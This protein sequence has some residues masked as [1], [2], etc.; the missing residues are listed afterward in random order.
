[1]VLRDLGMGRGV[2]SGN[3]LTREKKVVSKSQLYSH[4][5]SQVDKINVLKVTVEVCT[6]FSFKAFSRMPLALC[7]LGTS[8]IT[9]AKH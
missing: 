1:V 6:K 2:V 3:G 7:T 5:I 9:R 4:S 8:Y